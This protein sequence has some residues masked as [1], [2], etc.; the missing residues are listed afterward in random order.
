MVLLI[1]GRAKQRLSVTLVPCVMVVGR[2]EAELEPEM[3]VTPV[4]LHSIPGLMCSEPWIATGWG[5]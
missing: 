4:G 5:K 1:I 3:E 2:G